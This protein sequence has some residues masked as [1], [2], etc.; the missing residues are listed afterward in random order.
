MSEDR[1]R[2]LNE[3]MNDYLSKPVDL[4]ALR[5]VLEKWLSRTAVSRLETAGQCVPSSEIFNVKALMKRLL[6]DRE[7]AGTILKGYLSSTPRELQTLQTRLAE[8]DAAGTRLHAHMLKGSAATVAAESLSALA[9]ALERAGAAGKLSDCEE[10][11][12]RIVDEFDRFKRTL[13]RAGWV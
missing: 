5:A 1:L 10:I 2:C 3:G 7:L 6:E 4:E 13:E 8:A 12:P 11:L 9:A